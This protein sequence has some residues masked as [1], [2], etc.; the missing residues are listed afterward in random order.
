VIYQHANSIVK[1]ILTVNLEACKSHYDVTLVY[2]FSVCMSFCDT[3]ELLQVHELPVRREEARGEIY[4][5]LR[6]A[7]RHVRGFAPARP[8]A[9]LPASTVAVG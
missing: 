7:D 2:K 4:G 1:V 6:D 9:A 8:T 5:R 3:Q